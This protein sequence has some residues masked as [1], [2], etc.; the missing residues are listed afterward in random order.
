MTRYGDPELRTDA[1]KFCIKLP[2]LPRPI[3][4]RGAAEVGIRVAFAGDLDNR[5]LHFVEKN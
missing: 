4:G 2:E 5:I 3:T 1:E